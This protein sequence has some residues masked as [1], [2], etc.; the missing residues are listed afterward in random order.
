MKKFILIALMGLM[1]IGG[2][3]QSSVGLNAVHSTGVLNNYGIGVKLGYEVT[4]NIRVAPSFNYFFEKDQIRQLGANIDLQYLLKF[5]KA[6]VYPLVGVNYSNY[7]ADSSVDGWNINLGG[8]AEYNL[9]KNISV[10]VEAKHSFL[11]AY[12][13]KWVK[14]GIGGQAIISAGLTYKF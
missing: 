5:G 14:D 13:E 12:S 6:T 3:A 8:G 4:D 1:S 10:G 11:F 7:K 2:F 9:Y